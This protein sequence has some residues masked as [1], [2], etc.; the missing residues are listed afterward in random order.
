TLGLGSIAEMLR[1]W[2]FQGTGYIDI[3]GPWFA[4]AGWGLLRGH[5]RARSMAST[6]NGLVICLVGLVGFGALIVLV[7]RA[8]GYEM[9]GISVQPSPLLAVVLSLVLAIAFCLVQR[10][11]S[12]DEV[13]D[14]CNVKRAPLPLLRFRMEHLF[15]AMTLV[16]FLAWSHT[17]GQPPKPAGPTADYATTSHDGDRLVHRRVRYSTSAGPDTPVERV[18]VSVGD[19]GETVRVAWRG[20]RDVQANGATYTIDLD[21]RL[22][23]IRDGALSESTATM[24]RQEAGALQSGLRDRAVTLDN[25]LDTL[26]RLRTKTEPVAG[27]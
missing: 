21:Q 26:E 8:I 6:L 25:L 16:A 17:R 14:F 5:E 27:P 10:V 11:L 15:V 3:F 9:Q 7:G 23:V 13:R 18:L 19:A 4:Y 20:G 2:W 12:S 22:H 1:Q 24:T